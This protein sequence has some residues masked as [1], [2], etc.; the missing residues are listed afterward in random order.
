MRFL[1]VIWLAL[2]ACELQPSGCE[3]VGSDPQV[4][5]P[6]MGEAAAEYFI[7]RPSLVELGPAAQRLL[8][9]AG[10][11]SLCLTLPPIEGTSGDLDFRVDGSR[12][13]QPLKTLSVG[14][15]S[16]RLEVAAEFDTLDS[17]LMVAIHPGDPVKTCQLRIRLPSTRLRVDLEPAAGEPRLVPAAEAIW[18]AGGAEVSLS[19]RCPLPAPGD[20]TGEVVQRI[21]SALAEAARPTAE[22]L[23]DGIQKAAGLAG[24][25]RGAWTG[26][27]SDGRLDFALLPAAN[28]LTLDDA[29]LHLLFS[30]GFYGSPSACAPI[31]LLPWP[32]AS[33][34]PLWDFSPA[35]GQSFALGVSL[36]PALAAQALGEALRAGLLC[37]PAVQGM[38]LPLDDLLPSL[39][40]SFADPAARVAI[41]PG[42]PVTV[43]L[44]PSRPESPI[45]FSVGFQK[46]E[47][48]VFARLLGGEARILAL[49]VDVAAELA[50]DP[51][52]T[53]PRFSLAEETA[54]R[55]EIRHS[56]LLSEGAGDLRTRAAALIQR[57][58]GLAVA[59]LSP[60]PWEAPEVG[61][62]SR[63]AM[64]A[65]KGRLVFFFDA[66]RP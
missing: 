8:A 50:L 18:E 57:L 47:L 64:E 54:T 36:D 58:A 34:A 65:R 62:G 43:S 24:T 32:P 20:L 59:E 13:C 22:A 17:S 7:P 61:R 33:S 21:E 46:L 3:P 31:D 4:P 60:L 15:Q 25:A 14:P 12:L 52:A 35:G 37:R 2:A 66:Y 11:G 26:P 51:N 27:A 19:D 48:D 10:S 5:S 63:M 42:G 38:T 53:A 6:S 9:E 45:R 28:G 55:I 49:D 44:L 56:A 39:F 1:F 16:R 40:G 29:G 30:G 23:I 41:W